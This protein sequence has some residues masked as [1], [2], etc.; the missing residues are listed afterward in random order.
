MRDGNTITTTGQLVYLRVFELPMRDGNDI[1]SK[2][3]KL[4]IIVFLNFL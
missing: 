1:P 3:Y 2:P 4:S